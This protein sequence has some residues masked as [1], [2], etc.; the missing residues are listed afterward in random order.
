MPAGGEVAGAPWQGRP[1]GE[2]GQRDST[3]A[4]FMQPSRRALAEIVN[5][6]LASGALLVGGR[7]RLCGGLLRREGR[8]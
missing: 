4:A 7:F 8:R 1:A 3:R 2:E 5:E 6:A